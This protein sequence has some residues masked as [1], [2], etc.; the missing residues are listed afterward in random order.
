MP[1]N[2]F[3]HVMCS[4][5]YGE[6]GVLVNNGHVVLEFWDCYMCGLMRLWSMGSWLF[7]TE[8]KKRKKESLRFQE[9][10]EGSS[11]LGIDM[12]ENWAG[13]GSRSLGGYEN[14][15]TGQLCMTRV[16][17]PPIGW[18]Y[19]QSR[20]TPLPRGSFLSMEENHASYP[21][22]ENRS[23]ALGTHSSSVLTAFD[24]KQLC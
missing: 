14:P 18:L 4:I 5:R 20:L 11:E 13:T 19:G 21:S 6:I 16:S 24:K 12:R 22:L 2:I 23:P 15:Q 10:R 3:N 17:L 8:R 7:R 9:G 1:F